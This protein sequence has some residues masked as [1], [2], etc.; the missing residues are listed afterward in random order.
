[1]G[2][3]HSEPVQ[4]PTL[5]HKTVIQPS[6]TGLEVRL[7]GMST[8]N[9]GHLQVKYKGT[10]GAVCAAH[11]DLTYRSGEVICRQLHQGSPLKDSFLSKKC[12]PS[13]QGVKKT[14]FARI[15]CQG[16]EASLDQCNLKFLG[17]LENC[18]ACNI[19][20]VCLN[21]QPL[22]ANITGISKDVFI[23]LNFVLMVK[24]K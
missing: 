22:H 7:F 23:V 16:F 14:W 20:V 1:M 24:G 3:I 19:C 6:F 13:I 8:P 12:P 9:V 11:Q 17:G 5:I 4:Y 2:V 10:W 18:G 21:C 15:N